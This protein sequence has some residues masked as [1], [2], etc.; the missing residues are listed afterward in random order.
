MIPFTLIVGLI[1]F[2]TLFTCIT[3]FAKVSEGEFLVSV[4][5][6]VIGFCIVFGLISWTI[7]AK[8]TRE[9]LFE[10]NVPVQ[11]AIGYDKSITPYIILTY[12]GAE[13]RKKLTTFYPEGEM[14]KV[15]LKSKT[16]KGLSFSETLLVE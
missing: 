8:N 12:D 10:T 3:A 14:V 5:V 15:V 13:K 16:S 4:V 11:H 9:T 2:Y 7:N 6:F 1:V